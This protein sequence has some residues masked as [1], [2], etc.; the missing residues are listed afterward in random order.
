MALVLPTA[1]ARLLQST[2]LNSCQE[3]SGFTAS[4]FNVVYT[5]ENNRVSINMTAVSSVEGNVVFDIA[6]IAYGHTFMHMVINPC[7]AGLSGFCPMVAGKPSIP[8][9]FP[10]NPDATKD[11]PNIAYSLPDLDAKVRIFVNRTDGPDAGKSLAC[12]EALVSNGKTVD[13]AAVKWTAAII[14]GLGLVSA[15]VISALGYAN[16]GSHVASKAISLCGYF[17]SMALVGLVGI[18]LPP[19]AQAWTQDF[20]WSM[21]IIKV[22]FMQ[23]IFTWYQRATGGTPSRLFDSLRQVSVQVQK[24]SIPVMGPA[25]ALIK[26]SY[27]MIPPIREAASNLSKRGNIQIESGAYLV[28]GIQRAAFKAEIESTNVFMTGIIFY[29]IFAVLAGL[30]I[31]VFKAFCDTATKTRWVREDRFEDF[32]RGWR[33]I[34][35]GVLLRVTLIGFLPV[36]ILCF[37]EFTQNDSP[38]EVVL[39]VSFLFGMVICLGWAAFRVTQI[40]RR[41]VVLH[42][43]PAYGLFADESALNKWGVLFNTVQRHITTSHRFWPIL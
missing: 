21:G 18:P 42:R 4:L 14:V 19:I 24:R 35:K 16:A 38:A 29:C 2:S 12:M 1:A 3:D 22:G 5:P 6:V 26:R 13:L 33:A 17:Q 40:A 7:D 28:R 34:L 23:Q 41:S 32:R 25:V 27:A 37:W 9:A 31:M 15:G 10:L 43:N 20:Q 8:M 36:T 30:C 11:L 39:A